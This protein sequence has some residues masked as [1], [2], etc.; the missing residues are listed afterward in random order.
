M[1]DT[2]D[3]FGTDTAADKLE[4]YLNTL[5]IT[6]TGLEPLV[7]WHAIG[8]SNS[9]VCMAIDFLSAPGK[10]FRLILLT[11]LLIHDIAP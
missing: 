11:L 4:E 5:T 7:W 2:L 3:N 8:E 9:F 10:L 1:F 6:T